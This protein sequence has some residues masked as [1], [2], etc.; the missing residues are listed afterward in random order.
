[1]PKKLRRDLM[2]HKTVLTEKLVE[3][4]KSVLPITLTVFLLAFS[5]LP[6]D[7]DILL[8]FIVGAV[9]LTVGIG[10]FQLGADNSMSP[11]GSHIGAAL[12][13]SGKA[14]FLLFF[15]FLLGVI[16][17]VSEPDLQ[18]LAETFP[19]IPNATMIISVGVGVG[20]FLVVAILR[21]LLRVP[22]RYILVGFY[23]L[24]ILLS[25]FVDP[26]F[27]PVSFDSGGVTTGPMTVPTII[28]LGVGISALRQDSDAESDSLGYIALCSI[29]PILVMLI[30]SFFFPSS[31]EA[32]PE[33]LPH[34]AS[35]TELFRFFLKKIPFYLK[36][37][38]MAL[39]PICLLFLL[40]Q[41]FVLKLPRQAFGK[42]GIGIL[43]TYVGLV[44]FM[45]GANVGFMPLGRYIGE[46]LGT[47][48]YQWLI[49]PVA[50]VLGFF[51]VRAEPAVQ[52]L[53]KQVYDLTAGSIPE[54][55]MT[56]SLSIGV[57]L[58]VTLSFLRSYFAF[59][60]L[61]IVVP[62]YL[63]A[64][65]LTFF[66]DPI[67]TAIAFDSGGI[68]SGP[69]TSAFILPL[70]IGLSTSLGRD[71]SLYAFGIVSLVALTPII[72]V[73]TLGLSYK[74]LSARSGKASKTELDEEI[75]EL[76]FSFDRI[77]VFPSS[78]RTESS[79]E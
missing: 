32:S 63:I 49:V 8:F 70:S 50:F 77:P 35:T 59:S 7:S 36:E 54:K 51:T 67:F 30:L 71:V 16:I 78:E 20:L 41:I 28:A 34:A 3:S 68:A 62:G 12:T 33:I 60:I 19:G 14:W 40:F 75:I 38:L 52:V 45:T 17:T 79:H 18:I 24:T 9:L 72:T 31:S 73:L 66:V 15:S 37:V 6:I 21:V 11:I 56:F 26:S 58:A 5:V 55:A 74:I 23:G 10:L 46:M 13:R 42:I 65:L 43:Y 4:L 64:L 47:Q 25:F 48:S 39:L 1:M 76:P 27:L 57:G 61:W 44:I 2:F 22:L 69:L 29:G 53:T